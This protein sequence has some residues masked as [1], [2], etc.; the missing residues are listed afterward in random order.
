MNTRLVF[1]LLIFLLLTTKTYAL[2]HF[3]GRVIE[4]NSGNKGLPDVSVSSNYSKRPILTDQEGRFSLT[5]NAPNSK[6]L[7]SLRVEK[8]GYMVDNEG[9]FYQDVIKDTLLIY[10][11][12]YSDRIK[13][14][15]ELRHD[16][17]RVLHRSLVSV[18]D[19]ISDETDHIQRVDLLWKANYSKNYLKEFSKF[20][21]I[22]NFDLLSENHYLFLEK[23]RS[24]NNSH[25]TSLELNSKSRN[26]EILEEQL[27]L[28]R[29]LIYFKDSVSSESI[30]LP[31]FQ[32]GFLQGDSK[33][34]LNFSDKFLLET[35]FAPTEFE[36]FQQKLFQFSTLHYW[37]IRTK[38]EEKEYQS[39]R[40][41]LI[42]NLKVLQKFDKYKLLFTD[43]NLT[44]SRY[45][46]KIEN[47][48]MIYR[49]ILDNPK[50][51]DKIKDLLHEAWEYE[52]ISLTLNKYRLKGRV[53]SMQQYKM[54]SDL[55]A[56]LFGFQSE[57]KFDYYQGA[58]NYLGWDNKVMNDLE[59]ALTKEFPHF[60]SIDL[61]NYYR[62]SLNYYL[63]KKDS[64]GFLS[65]ANK[66]TN[67]AIQFDS[68]ESRDALSLRSRIDFLKAEFY[69]NSG[70]LILAKK[71]YDGLLQ[72]I[73]DLNEEGV[74]ADYKLQFIP[75][76][77]ING[78]LM[79]SI[80][81][82]E[83]EFDIDN[84]S[85]LTKVLPAEYLNLSPVFS[86]TFSFSSISLVEDNF[87]SLLRLTED[88]NENPR[89]VDQAVIRER[90][91]SQWKNIIEYFPLFKFKVAFIENL[92]SQAYL[93]LQFS[94]PHAERRLLDLYDKI[95]FLSDL[96]QKIFMERLDLTLALAYTLNDNW[97]EAESILSNYKRK[98]NPGNSPKE[99]IIEEVQKLLNLGYPKEKLSKVLDL[100]L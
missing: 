19:T 90:M 72:A 39:L 20:V 28:I 30:Y 81:N 13:Y 85:K 40:S 17:N 16:L 36:E 26:E 78:L 95:G 47:E 70:N 14:Q 11:Y 34:R 71:L 91:T 22:L 66:Y 98:S 24:G 64:D 43:R 54:L 58:T 63:T 8:D 82:I 42:R 60:Y 48:A 21:S 33:I 79:F 25:L 53:R 2:T 61:L 73:I 86:N 51:L 41:D 99:F 1:Y 12:D 59:T 56:E 15:N 4:V 3:Y 62:S 37:K 10:M 87:K 7:Q 94:P 35:N 57:D 29:D 75:K 88:L 55:H 9:V 18:L 84:L 49:S 5:V 80:Q 52:K 89:N 100:F 31:F 23:I 67:Y 68:G 32:Y 27:L 92:Y 65:L 96:E 93:E 76:L 77:H 6:A 38:K 45:E 50:V 44:L 69:S 97:E 83:N 46:G 74:I